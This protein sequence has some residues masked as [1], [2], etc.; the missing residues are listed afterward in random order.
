MVIVGTYPPL[1]LQSA[2]RSLVHLPGAAG[3]PVSAVYHDEVVL[4]SCLWGG[5]VPAGE[6]Y[7][8]GYLF[9]PRSYLASVAESES[10]KQELHTTP[11][12]TAPGASQ[13][14]C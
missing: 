7:A 2:K 4:E 5:Y 9:T 13:N 11:Y 6:T 8:I 3:Y 10:M 1:G 14:L 12:T